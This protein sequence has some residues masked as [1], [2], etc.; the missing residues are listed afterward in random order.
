MRV[1]ILVNSVKLIK[2]GINPLKLI[3]RPEKLATEH[4]ISVAKILSMTVTELK[5]CLKEDL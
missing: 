3:F 1:I 4:S 5:E 2:I